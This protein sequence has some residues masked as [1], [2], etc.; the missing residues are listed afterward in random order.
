[1]YKILK[2]HTPKSVK[3]TIK[4]FTNRLD[5]IK[6]IILRFPQGSVFSSDLNLEKNISLNKKALL[7]TQVKNDS[8]APVAL[9]AFDVGSYTGNSI[10]RLRAMG[11][12]EIV[13]FEPDPDNYSTLVRSF[14]GQP[15]LTFFNYAVSDRSGEVLTLTSNRD[16]P[17]LNTLNKDWIEE[18]RHEQFFNRIEKYSVETI[19]L[20]DALSFYG[21][22]P[23]YIKID[24]EGHEL[25]VLKGLS[26]KPK[27]L[28]FEW[29]SEKVEKNI[30]AVM[31]LQGSLYTEFYVCSQ[32]DLP[33]LE[34]PGLDFNAC[35][36]FLRKLHIEDVENNKG[37]NIFCR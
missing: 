2:Q 30:S 32:E 16:C 15:G 1:M 22:Y 36:D 27:L 37:G 7:S 18:T 10:P 11:Y 14:R 34:K 33:E 8:L 17:W 31:Y 5:K 9:L 29:I 13:C 12:S 19:T 23:S 3:K 6:R 26:F 25:N 35:I 24:V 4:I 21:R 28:S 20:D